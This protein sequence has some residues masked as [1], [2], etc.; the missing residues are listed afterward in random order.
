MLTT[1]FSDCEAASLTMLQTSCLVPETLLAGLNGS[2]LTMAVA[3]NVR[4]CGSADFFVMASVRRD[5]DRLVHCC[6]VFG[7]GE[8][9]LSNVSF[10]A[11]GPTSH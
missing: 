4:V 5:N 8:S 11:V 2:P 9:H 3:V 7:R 1:G 6:I 10:G